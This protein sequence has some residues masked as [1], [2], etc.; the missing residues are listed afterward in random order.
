MWLVVI[1]DSGAGVVKGGGGA[2]GGLYNPEMRM[3]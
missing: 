2:A 1:C 3:K